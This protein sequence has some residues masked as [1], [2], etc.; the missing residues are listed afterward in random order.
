MTDIDLLDALKNAFNLK[1]D[2]EIAKFLNVT[3]TTVH[4]IRFKSTGLGINPKLIVL[5]RMF[6]LNRS[7]WAESISVESLTKLILISNGLTIKTNDAEFSFIDAIKVLFN[8]DTDESL[9]AVLGVARNTISMVRSG[10]SELGPKPKLKI[11]NKLN[12]FDLTLV[13]LALDSND[14]LIEALNDWA[15]RKK[16]TD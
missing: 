2:A 14:A 6:F 7:N 13:E 16:I 3:R 1:N 10:R 4:A 11:L 5:S 8:F 9:S 15:S 12:P